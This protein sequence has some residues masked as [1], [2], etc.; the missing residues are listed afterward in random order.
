MRRR[1]ALVQQKHG[2]L[3]TRDAATRWAPAAAAIVLLLRR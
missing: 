1:F 2:E 3:R